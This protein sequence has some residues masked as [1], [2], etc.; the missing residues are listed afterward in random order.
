MSA[1]NGLVGEGK[2][3][4]CVNMGLSQN[5]GYHHDSTMIPYDTTKCEFSTNSGHPKLRPCDDVSS[6]M[7]G[8]CTGS[9]FPHFPAGNQHLGM[10]RLLRIVLL[11]DAPELAIIVLVVTK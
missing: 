10:L 4:L 3:I 11:D 8:P 1:D 6:K 5:G 7:L 2:K 9:I